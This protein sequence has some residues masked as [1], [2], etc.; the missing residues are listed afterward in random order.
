MSCSR[1]QRSN[2]SEAR[3]L[4]TS[5]LSLSHCSPSKQ[6]RHRLLIE[7]SVDIEEMKNVNYM[8][9]ANEL[10]CGEICSIGQ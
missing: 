1:T 9:T 8:Y 10:C 4:E 5:T 2:A 7:G 6:C 3:T